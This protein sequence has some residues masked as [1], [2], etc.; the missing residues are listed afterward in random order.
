MLDFSTIIIYNIGAIEKS[1]QNHTKTA[2]PLKPK[3][4]KK[5]DQV[6]KK[7]NK[8]KKYKQHNY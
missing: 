2:Q 5:A 3:K 8:A 6:E 4:R 7:K 1:T